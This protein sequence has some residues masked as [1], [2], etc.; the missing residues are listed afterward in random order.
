MLYY[1]LSK[2][3]PNNA[4]EDRKSVARI[5]KLIVE[6]KS[7]YSGIYL[8]NF[9][10][11]VNMSKR[12]IERDIK[13]LKESGFNIQIEKSKYRIEDSQHQLSDI[14]DLIHFNYSELRYIKEVLDK[15]GIQHDLSQNILRKIGIITD[16]S[17][18]DDDAF[19]PER[20]E[21]L[22]LLDKAIKSKKRVC[23][24]DYSSANSNISTNRMVEPFEIRADG[25]M[26]YAYELKS[27]RVKMFKIGRIGKVKIEKQD[28]THQS[29]HIKPK[30][31]AF[32]MT[33]DQVYQVTLKLNHRAA[34]LMMEEY[35]KTRNFIKKEKEEDIFIY[36]DNVFD[37]KGIG[38]FV[39]SLLDS[40][41]IIEPQ[42]LKDFIY[43]NLK[44]HYMSKSEGRFANVEINQRPI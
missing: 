6:L 41:E 32:S 28:Q 20:A 14:E 8:K 39:F 42:E 33:G 11:K 36:S 3:N 30:E 12:T 17:L 34:H 10:Q 38:R 9:A 19:N 1:Y 15:S 44:R 7:T 25:R 24:R 23:L 26:L 40:I 29:L 2:S 31:D 37:L 35:P 43:E 13:I 4:M 21:K 27:A 5:L 22:H 18:L 16:I